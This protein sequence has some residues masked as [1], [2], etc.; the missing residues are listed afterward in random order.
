[1]SRILLVIM[2]ELERDFICTLL[3]VRFGRQVTSLAKVIQIL[4]LLKKRYYYL[5][6]KALNCKTLLNRETLNLNP[7]SV[8]SFQTPSSFVLLCSVPQPHPL[9]FAGRVVR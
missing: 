2:K 4:T 1:M 5:T 3:S 6:R 7:Y 9:I 8:E